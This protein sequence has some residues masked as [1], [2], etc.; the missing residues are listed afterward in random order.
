[1]QWSSSI[2]RSCIHIRSLHFDKVLQCLNMTTLRCHVNRGK[3]IFIFVVHCC[4]AET[5][6]GALQVV[7]ASS[8]VSFASVFRNVA[9]LVQCPTYVS[10]VTIA[11]STEEP[12]AP[13]EVPEDVHSA[14]RLLLLRTIKYRN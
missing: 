12:A 14:W 8:Q 2:M 1:M 3:P 11:R 7:C 10:C 6:D 5:G 13:P 4:K 9:R